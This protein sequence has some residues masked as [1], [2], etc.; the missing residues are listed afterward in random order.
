MAH[1]VIF[2]P[3]KHVQRCLLAQ[4]K[5]RWHCLF[6]PFNINHLKNSV[7]YTWSDSTSKKIRLSAPE[8]IDYMTTH[9]ENTLNEE[10]IFPTKSGKNKIQ[11][12][13]EVDIDFY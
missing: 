1:L 10:S 7:E 11:K 5:I 13:R 4:G 8:Y 12:E 3:R 9:L 2:V 6:Y